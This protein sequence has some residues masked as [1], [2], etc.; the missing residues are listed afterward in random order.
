MS[1]DEIARKA[2]E[3]VAERIKK[4]TNTSAEKARQIAIDSAR[5]VDRQEK[6]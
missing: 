6:R 5:R 4:T 2:I 3:K 1:K